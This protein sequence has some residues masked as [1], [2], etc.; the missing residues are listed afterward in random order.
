MALS[1]LGIAASFVL[2]GLFLLGGAA[3]ASRPAT[4]VTFTK[5]VAPIIFNNCA[6]C[7]RPGE[8][9]PMSFLTYK[10]VRPWAKSIREAVVGRTMPPWGA[11]PQHGEFRNDRRLSQKD[12]DTITAWVDG[13]AKEGDPKDIPPSPKFVDGWQIGTPDVILTA[14]EFNVPA[15]GVVPY[16]TFAVPTNF[17]EDK[18]VVLAEIR[19]GNRSVVHHA[20]IYTQEPG[21]GTGT[22]LDN[23]LVGLAPGATPKTYRLGRVKVV[24]KGSTLMFSMHYTP[25]GTAA[26]DQTCVG[27]VFAKGPVEKRVIT[28][29][30]GTRNF[31]IPAGDPS[32][33]VKASWPFKEDSHI[34]GLNPH[35]HARGKDFLYTLVYPD[36]TKKVLLWVPRYDF[37]WQMSYSFKEPVAAPK[38]SRLDCIAHFDN[39]TKN[40]YNPDPAQVVRYGDQTWDEMMA[41]YLEYTVDS[42]NLVQETAKLG[43]AASK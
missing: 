12:V 24:K 22:W 35:M 8:I 14:Q 30:A 2:A 21:G 7:H 11:D 38:G 19:P 43:S 33:E 4:S 6:A 10:Q 39:S 25:N 34:E 41:G 31:A 32:H 42:Q 1:R 37:N 5:D 26:K 16:K 23:M 27:L 40:K 29:I 28:A 13:G 20:V 15:D 17:T 18:Y 3:V 9:A 36:G